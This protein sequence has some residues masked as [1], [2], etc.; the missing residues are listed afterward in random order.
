MSGLSTM[1]NRLYRG[2][3]S[4]Q[5]VN[6]RKRWLSIFGGILLL[7]ILGLAVRGLSFSVDFTGGATVTVPSATLSI[8]QAT[9][10]AL[11]DGLVAPT[12]QAATIIGGGRQVQITAKTITTAQQASLSQDLAKEAGVNPNSVDVS[13]TG[14]SWGKSVSK[15]AAEALIVFL[16]LV[17][18][19][20]AVFFEWQMAA[21]SI[22]SLLNVIVITVG[23]YAWSGQEVSPAT[24]TGF[25]TIL[26]YALYDTVVVFDKVRENVKL[27]VKA[28]KLGYGDSA[29]LAVNQTLVRSLNTSLIATIPV[30]ALLIGGTLSDAAELQELALALFV[31]IAAGT[32]SSILVATPFLVWLKERDPAIRAQEK[33][34]DR[35][36]SAAPLKTA[37]EAGWAQESADEALVDN[38]R[39]VVTT[40][41]S[42]GPEI[43]R[44][45]AQRNQPVRTTK[46]KR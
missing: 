23:V 37:V 20:L 10:I 36:K 21:A 6:R 2:E 26:G 34:L 29:N 44:N 22:V 24:V 8:N 14:A 38:P 41:G 43:R 27:Q 40:G 13:Q 5:I 1:G 7:A 17:A 12:V 42:A 11:N 4:F 19:Y 32:I 16:F 28:D 30:F 45:P 9:Q 46:K 35:K 39:I 15:Q 18:I 31:G 25:L 3:V 33:R